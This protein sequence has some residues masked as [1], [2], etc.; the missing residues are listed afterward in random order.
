MFKRDKEYYTL[1]ILYIAF[2]FAI[3]LIF[4]LIYPQKL[5]FALSFITLHFVLTA[6]AESIKAGKIEYMFTQIWS[7]QKKSEKWAVALGWWIPR[8][9]RG[10]IVGDILED[11]HEMRELGCGEWRIFIQ[12]IWQWAI[13]IATLIP[14]AIF[15]SIWRI[16]SAPK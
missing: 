5:Y 13:A 3:I 12:V 11:C 8:K 16:F 7:T 9:H 14:T 1:E 10:P 6:L 15:G 2:F 4:G